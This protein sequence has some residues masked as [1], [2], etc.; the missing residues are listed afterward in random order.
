[1]QTTYQPVIKVIEETPYN[2]GFPLRA[3]EFGTSPYM[4]NITLR[5][6]IFKLKISGSI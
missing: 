1:M 6:T 2:P 5:I 4:V 3:Y